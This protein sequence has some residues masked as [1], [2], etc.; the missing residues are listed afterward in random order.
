MVMWNNFLI[1][2][3]YNILEKHRNTHSY[4]ILTNFEQTALLDESK[5]AE[6][7]E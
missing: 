6:D 7:K 3:F 5:L 1:S 4:A 2:R